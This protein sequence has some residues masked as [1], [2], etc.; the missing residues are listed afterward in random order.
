MTRKK[1]VIII[2]ASALAAVLVLGAV[3][4]T[5]YRNVQLDRLRVFIVDSL[6]EKDGKPYSLSDRKDMY[7][8]IDIKGVYWNDI[9]S[10][11][12][13]LDK[14]NA[15]FHDSMG[16][17]KLRDN[18]YSQVDRPYYTII[19]HSMKTTLSNGSSSSG[20]YYKYDIEYSNG[21]WNLLYSDGPYITASECTPTEFV[22][23]IL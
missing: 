8:A 22:R 13:Y 11:I 7:D 18:F 6:L 3:A 16:D 12:N 21:Q 23:R 5:I 9:K 15:T 14:T 1:K 10:E 19:L 2:I 4:F 20:G 17:E